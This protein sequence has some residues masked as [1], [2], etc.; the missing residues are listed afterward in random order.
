MSRLIPS[1]TDHVLG[2]ESK[3]EKGG[4]ERP[5]PALYP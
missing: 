4:K 1:D 3:R 5:E 2:Y